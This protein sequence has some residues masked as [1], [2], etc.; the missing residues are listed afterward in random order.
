MKAR[1]DERQPARER[2][3]SSREEMR[4]I[5]KK[6]KIKTNGGTGGA[7]ILSSLRNLGNSSKKRHSM[8]TEKGS[9]GMS[10]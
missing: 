2:R 4:E 5:H 9:P 10:G 3:E 8:L 6:M 7:E 1:K